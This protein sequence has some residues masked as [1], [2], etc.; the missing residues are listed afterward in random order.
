MTK[1]LV[2]SIIISLF[3][4]VIFLA[5]CN[6]NTEPLDENPNQVDLSITTIDYY[7]H[8]QAGFVY[9]DERIIIRVVAMN[10]DKLPEK[11]TYLYTFIQTSGGNYSF[12]R[13]HVLDSAEGTDLFIDSD[14]STEKM[15]ELSFKN[16]G[17][18]KLR[19]DLYDSDEYKSLGVMAPRYGTAEYHFTVRAIEVEVESEL[20]GEG[21]YRF[22]P[23]I[24][25]PE[26]GPVIWAY[27]FTF[28]DGKKGWLQSSKEEGSSDT[29]VKTG[30]ESITHE[31]TKEGTY[32]VE[33]ET[34]AHKKPD[35]F[36]KITTNQL[37]VSVLGSE[38]Y[39]EVPDA[40]LKTGQEYTLK[41]MTSG[42]LPASPS[43]EWDF[44]DRSGLTIPL[45][46]E[47]THLYENAGT[48]TVRVEL[49]ESEEEGAPLLGVATLDIVVGG[50]SLSIIEAYHNVK[51]IDV[52]I[53]TWIIWRYEEGKKPS[54][55]A[56]DLT[57][58]DT[59]ATYKASTKSS[60]ITWQGTE[61]EIKSSDERFTCNGQISDDGSELLY[62]NVNYVWDSGTKGSSSYTLKNVPIKKST[63]I[64]GPPDAIELTNIFGYYSFEFSASGSEVESYVSSQSHHEEY[65][66]NGIVAKNYDSWDPDRADRHNFELKF[67]VT[68]GD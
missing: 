52:T 6:S 7:S 55:T 59:Q 44:G 15:E 29:L 11:T 37:T 68:Q 3:T 46:N 58:G 5:S 10:R 12:E 31:Y 17:T 41:A 35:T 24:L 13:E 57:Y 60:E 16:E 43:Y 28:G 42:L 64:D 19:C 65:D 26:I 38:F 34:L 22:T 62:L 48:Y 33:V 50:D 2:I 49:F 18:Y 1:Y 20:L 25:N 4:G 9:P 14:E 40:P 32:R 30:V 63:G 21:T 54:P 23:K 47:A 36:Q 61:F 8:T 66:L 67:Y 39:I 51:H 53:S 56:G 45:S 27:Q